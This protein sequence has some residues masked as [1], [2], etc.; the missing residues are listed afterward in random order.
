[1]SD[2]YVV[3][4]I[5]GC[6]SCPCFCDDNEGYGTCGITHEYGLPAPLEGMKNK[7]GS[8]IWVLPGCKIFVEGKFIIIKNGN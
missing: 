7:F 6:N 2:E 1:M 3:E 8:S 5:G 4:L